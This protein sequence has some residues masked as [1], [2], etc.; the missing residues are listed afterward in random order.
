MPGCTPAFPGFCAQG[1][2]SKAFPPRA[3]GPSG[4][5]ESLYLLPACRPR[6]SGDPSGATARSAFAANAC[7]G[8]HGSPLSRGRHEISESPCR[9]R[10]RSAPATG[11]GAAKRQQ[12]STFVNI[13]Q[14]ARKHRRQH[15]PAATGPQDFNSFQQRRTHAASR[16][17]KAPHGPA[18]RRG[19][20]CPKAGHDGYVEL[21]KNI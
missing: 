4:K 9:R 20:A 14:H 19:A 18:R 8:R 10:S 7:Q 3:A 21:F 15:P 17:S 1:A 5:C 12:T 13:R 2:T 11:D 6:E 16:S